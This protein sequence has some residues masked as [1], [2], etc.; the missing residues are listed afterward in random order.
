MAI[1]LGPKGGL[2]HAFALAAIACAFLFKVLA[3]VPAPNATGETFGASQ[4]VSVS[5]PAEDCKS[6]A[7]APRSGRHG[8]RGDC[9]L[10]ASCGAGTR[11]DR[12]GSPTAA[13]ELAPTR[14]VA[15]WRSGDD[16]APSSS[17][18]GGA[19]RARAPPASA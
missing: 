4:A 7:G 12:A 2:T 3:F 15:A 14:D 11:A 18:S 1:I 5:L 19:W 9:A 10:C 6:D 17:A 13:V 16:G 8:D